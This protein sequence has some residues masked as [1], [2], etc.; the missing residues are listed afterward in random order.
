MGKHDVIH[1]SRSTWHITVSSRRTEP[2]RTENFVKFGLVIWLFW[3]MPA[4]RQT[5]IQTCSSQ[6]FA[7]PPV[8]EWKW[9][10]ERS[11]S[12]EVWIALTLYTLDWDFWSF[13]CSAFNC[14]T[15]PH[16][17]IAILRWLLA[18]S[19]GSAT[20][21]ACPWQCRLAS[22]AILRRSQRLK[23]WQNR[24]ICVEN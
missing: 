24:Q 23:N 13:T 21:P 17:A 3:D 15:C 11:S 9:P 4:D 19:A 14:W 10:T 18:T 1:K 12:G 2:T 22:A 20:T 16:K 5:D 8:A 6:Y 7:L